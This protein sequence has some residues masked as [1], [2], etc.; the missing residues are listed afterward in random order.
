M[1][2][3]INKQMKHGIYQS[4]FKFFPRLL[5]ALWMAPSQHLK[6]LPSITLTDLLQPY[7]SSP[8]KG[9]VHFTRSLS[10]ALANLDS[11]ALF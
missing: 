8:G 4:E 1:K 6:Q 5:I 2:S 3:Q 7:V 11:V 10:S 9:S